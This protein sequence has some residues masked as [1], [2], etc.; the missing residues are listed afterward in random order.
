V[1]LIGTFL[2]FIPTVV[3]VVEVIFSSTAPACAALWRGEPG[4]HG[5]TQF[6]RIGMTT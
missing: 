4:F 3:A 1:P 6:K 2:T 5:F